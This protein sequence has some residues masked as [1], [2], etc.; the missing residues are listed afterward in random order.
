M[1][2]RSDL[3]RTLFLKDYSYLKH[4]FWVFWTVCVFIVISKQSH[5][6]QQISSFFLKL[7]FDHLLFSLVFAYAFV[8]VIQVGLI[9]IDNI[10]DTERF[11]GTRPVENYS[12]VIASKMATIVSLLIF[13]LAVI[14]TFLSSGQGAFPL[15]NFVSNLTGLLTLSILLLLLILST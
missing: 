3:L 12:T 9:Q 1:N 7:N 2:S 4:W 13:P 10:Q 8:A 5:L 6:S 11:L 14:I 15:I